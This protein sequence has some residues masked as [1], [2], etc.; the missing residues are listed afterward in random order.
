[1]SKSDESKQPP[2]LHEIVCRRLKGVVISKREKQPVRCSLNSGPAP[3]RAATLYLTP[4][5]TIPFE[6]AGQRGRYDGNG[7]WH[8]Q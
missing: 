1:M 6:L 8:P 7:A 3:L 5:G 2:P 4:G